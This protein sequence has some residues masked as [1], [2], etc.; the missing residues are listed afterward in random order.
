M[1]TIGLV[2]RK[3]L[4]ARPVA[5]AYELTELGLSSLTILQQ[6]KARAEKTACD[7]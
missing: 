1:E 6:L 2:K 7:G 3:V 5:V 4:S